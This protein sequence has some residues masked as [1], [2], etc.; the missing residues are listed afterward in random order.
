MSPAGQQGL[1]LPRRSH[2]LERVSPGLKTGATSGSSGRRREWA[3]LC[4]SARTH[5]HRDPQQH[6]C[7]PTPSATHIYPHTHTRTHVYAYTHVPPCTCT[8]TH[9]P[10]RTCTP[11]T[12][13]PHTCT[14]THVYPPTCTPHACTPHTCT[15]M[16]MYSHICVP[17]YTCTPPHMYPHTCVP[18]HTPAGRHPPTVATRGGGRGP[19][20][21]AGSSTAASSCPPALPSRDEGPAVGRA[22]W[23]GGYP[24]KLRHGELGFAPAD[25]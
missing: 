5:I 24:G 12:C 25:R 1:T 19:G 23:G 4:A 21:Q 18:L 20:C 16:H 9:V 13:T 6:V 10:P 2:S 8:S 7:K 11:R 3:P 17:P 15:P 22:W 14:P